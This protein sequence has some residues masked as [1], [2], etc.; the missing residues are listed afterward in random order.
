MP[1]RLPR[2][3]S[4]P[5]VFAPIRRIAS[6]C[7]LALAVPAIAGCSGDDPGPTVLGTSS[8]SPSASASASP[9]HTPSPS[10]SPALLPRPANADDYTAEGMKA[11]T[12]Y[13]IDAFNRAYATGD[14]TTLKAISTKNCQTCDAVEKTVETA[15]GPGGHTAGGQMS[16]LRLGTPGPLNGV[17][18]SVVVDLVV[19]SYKRYGKQGKVVESVKADS[20]QL[21]FD[22]ARKGGVWWLNGVRRGSSQ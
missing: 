7:V 19:T 6:V 21:I 12:R 13:A 10:T 14:L 5:R 18:P 4:L 1:R 20:A 22:L 15:W 11:F 9:S 2:A 16:E 3:G 17:R 8:P